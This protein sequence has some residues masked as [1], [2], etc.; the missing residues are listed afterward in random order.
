[1]KDFQIN[2]I[3]T[4]PKIITPN[5]L[6][7]ASNMEIRFQE[8]YPNVKRP[9]FTKST[10]EDD[11]REIKIIGASIVLG[12]FIFCVVGFLCM[13]FNS[14]FLDVSTET[15]KAY[16]FPTIVGISIV[17]SLVI[18]ILS[19]KGIEQER[20]VSVEN[21]KLQFEKYQSELEK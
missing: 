16:W 18:I 2:H 13:I 17:G 15:W 5:Y 20:K 12:F 11:F 8:I 14:I 7:D 19:F 4:Y 9:I 21:E 3:K 1:M 6:K 10:K